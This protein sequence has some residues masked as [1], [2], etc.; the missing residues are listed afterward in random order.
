MKYLGFEPDAAAPYYFISYNSEDAERVRPV[1]EELKKKG[2]PLWYDYG[3]PYDSKWNSVITE[4]IH[5]CE[6]VILFY[7]NGII[8]KDDP[9]VIKEYRMARLYHKPI[10]VILLDQIDAAS[11]PYDKVDWLIELSK[12]HSA[13]ETDGNAGTICTETLRF[14]KALEDKTD[15]RMPGTAIEKRTDTQA[16]GTAYENKTVLGKAPG[17]V[18]QMRLLRPFMAAAA[19]LAAVC[20]SLFVYCSHFAAPEINIT[21]DA[22]KADANCAQ[23]LVQIDIRAV[24]CLNAIDACEAYLDQAVSEAELKESLNHYK[25]AIEKETLISVAEIPDSYP[26]RV[27]NDD[28]LMQASASTQY[29]DY[30]SLCQWLILDSQKPAYYKRAVLSELRDI[31]EQDLITALNRCRGAI[32]PIPDIK[33]KKENGKYSLVTMGLLFDNTTASAINPF[34][35]DSLFKETSSVV[36]QD[37]VNNAISSGMN[38]SQDL[39]TKIKERIGDKWDEYMEK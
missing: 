20:I 22:R 8:Q 4:K 17:K 12:Y 37:D 13:A 15:S 32:F 5:E 6:A 38:H 35:K 26:G 1:A 36:T 7:T 10:F 21:T 24:S 11:A 3:I 16:S 23:A 25:Q 14:I 31:I 19:L 29:S 39:K 27:F 30:I 28:L 9:Y 33:E 2:I 18:R 34:I